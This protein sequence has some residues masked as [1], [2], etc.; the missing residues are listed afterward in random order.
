MDKLTPLSLKYSPQGL[1][2]G[3]PFS[4]R[5]QR[6]VLIVPQLEHLLFIDLRVACLKNKDK[7]EGGREG[8]KRDIYIYIIYTW[9]L[10]MV[11]SASAVNLYMLCLKS[12]NWQCSFI[13]PGTKKVPPIFQKRKSFHLHKNRARGDGPHGGV[14]MHRP[15]AHTMQC[16]SGG[17]VIDNPWKQGENE[18]RGSQNLSGADNICWPCWPTKDVA[19]KGP[20]AT[21]TRQHPLWKSESIHGLVTKMVL[22]LESIFPNILS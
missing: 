18:W 3:S 17:W 7:R 16:V 11:E 5:L 21:S 1:H 12:S 20:A 9:Q 14:G 2:T 22:W 19:E 6:T 8:E 4:I 10:T 15:L 13:S